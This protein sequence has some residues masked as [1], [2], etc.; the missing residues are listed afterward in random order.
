MDD[1]PVLKID[2]MFVAYFVLLLYVAP[3]LLPVL[4]YGTI[5]ATENAGP[6]NDGPGHFKA[7]K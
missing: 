5:G 6:E 2:K 4:A 7:C 3:F 1:M